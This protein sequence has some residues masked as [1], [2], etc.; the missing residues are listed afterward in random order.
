MSKVLLRFADH[1][2]RRI[3][4]NR[5]QLSRL[6]ARENFPPGFLITANSR[7]WLEEEID[8][9]I[10]SRRGRSLGPTVGQGVAKRRVEAA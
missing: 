3:V 7:C 4:S 8:G 10:D 5:V 2:E 1:Q 6:I 9:W